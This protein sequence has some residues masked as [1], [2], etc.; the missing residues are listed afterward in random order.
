MKKKL[1]QHTIYDSRYSKEDYD[2]LAEDWADSQND[3]ID[4]EDEKVSADDYDMELYYE[5]KQRWLDDEKCN[6]NKQLDGV[7]IAYAR[8]GLWDGVHIGYMKLGSNFNSIF[9]NF[10]CD[11]VHFFADRF[12]VRADAWHHDGVNHIL[13]RLCDEEKADKVC[14]KVCGGC[15]E[16]EFMRMTKSI[17]NVPNKVYGW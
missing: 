8:L 14:A 9:R 6:L 2:I 3:F 16:K 4:D 10:S 5:E 1:K 17:V 7:I 12:N 13:F 11:D 15:S